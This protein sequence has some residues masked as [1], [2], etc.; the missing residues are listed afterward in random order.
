MCDTFVSLTDGGV[1]FGKN[2]DRDPNEAQLLRW[3]PAA[4]HDPAATVD[5]T[6]TTIPQVARTHAVVLS[7]PWWM[8]G[9]EI[10][11]NE[12]GVV[13]GNEAVFT[14]QPL[15]EPALLG[16]DLL[17]LALERASSAADAVEV[18]VTLLETHGQGGPCS[19]ERPG[20]SYHNSFLVADAA[21]AIVLETAGSAWA[22]EGVTGAGRAISNG[23]TIDGFADAHANRLKG[24]VAACAV[25]RARLEGSAAGVQGPADAFAALRDHGADPSPTWSRV[26]GA[27]SAPCAHA[28]GRVTSTQTT[29]S[30]VADLRGEPLHW[31]TATSAPCTS[32]FKPIRVGQPH[33]GGGGADASASNRF[34]PAV[35]WWRHELVHRLALRDHAASVARWSGVAAATE[36]AW[37]ADPPRTDH[38]FVRAEELE[39]AWLDDLVGAEL[40][41][42]RPRWLRSLWDELD[43]AAGIPVGRALPAGVR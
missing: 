33:L 24:R 36:A 31:A 22:T 26:N 14:T 25:R 19:H 38:A 21:G 16:M 30:W 43:Q 37:V 42:R 11:A 29:S 10:G 18:L 7:Q 15:G 41:D 35:G 13:I 12:H 5:C 28:G 3:H 40:P 20:F 8:W 9:A 32:L 1:V 39:A 17:R 34:D 27:L 6:W 2:S 23:L 4:H